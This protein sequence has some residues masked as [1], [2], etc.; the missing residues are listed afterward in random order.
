MCA[1]GRGDVEYG[2]DAGALVMEG[3]G[4]L[5]AVCGRSSELASPY[6]EPGISF[7]TTPVGTPRWCRYG[8][9]AVACLVGSSGVPDLLLADL[10]PPLAIIAF[11]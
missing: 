3:Y 1:L 11:A 9:V 4:L 10:C 8:G 6:P 7:K 5:T 2:A